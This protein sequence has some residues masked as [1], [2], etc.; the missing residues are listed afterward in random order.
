MDS[1]A[2][3]VPVPTKHKGGNVVKREVKAKEA[4]RDIR[5]GMDDIALMEKYKL[6]DKGLRSLFRRLLAAG[7]VTADE[8]DGRD[9]PFFST[10][11]LDMDLNGFLDEG[12]K[13]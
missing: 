6:N 5:S 1:C 4:I 11:T 13:D 12:R 8:I 2:A 10:V 3:S 9:S 7:L